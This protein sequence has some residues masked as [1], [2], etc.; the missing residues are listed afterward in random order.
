MAGRAKRSPGPGPDRH[1]RCSQRV[2]GGSARRTWRYRPG[3]AR[4]RPC[5]P[6]WHRDGHRDG[7][8]RRRSPPGRSSRRGERGAFPP[9][10]RVGRPPDPA[11][12]SRSGPAGGRRQ[13]GGRRRWHPRGEAA[14]AARERRWRTWG[15][16]WGSR[17]CPA[18]RP[19][20]GCPREGKAMSPG[21][22]GRLG[23]VV[24]PSV[25]R[26]PSRA[27]GLRPTRWGHRECRCRR[28]EPESGRPDRCR[29]SGR[30]E[31]LRAR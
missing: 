8:R 5:P 11:G 26:G 9:G 7:R 17:D 6:G 4:A 3:R 25:P 22:K 21:V 23:P 27:G 15:P 14:G 29:R 12:S 18:P 28:R 31:C 13:R 16:P 20:G 10:R 24:Q 30:R 2:R 1:G 19:P